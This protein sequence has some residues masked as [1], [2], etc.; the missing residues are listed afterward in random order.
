[1]QTRQTPRKTVSI[2]GRYFTGTGVPVDVTVREISVGGCRFESNSPHLTTGVRVQIE[3][4][5][6]GP[7]HGT[8]KWVENGEIGV[9]FARKLADADLAAFQSSHI[10]AATPAAPQSAFRP[11][12]AAKQNRFC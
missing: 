6:T 7:H 3:I 10:P 12:K 9:T 8:I 5:G 4:A 1:M 2:P 11:M